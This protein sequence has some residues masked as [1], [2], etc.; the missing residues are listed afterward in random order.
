MRPSFPPERLFVRVA[1]NTATPRTYNAQRHARLTAQMPDH[2]LPPI[3]YLP[4]SGGYTGSRIVPEVFHFCF[5]HRKPDR[6]DQYSF[7]PPTVRGFS[8]VAT[9]ST[10]T[11][12]LFVRPGTWHETRECYPDI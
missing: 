7:R 8:S 12:M 9:A 5:L 3:V 2:P 6:F 10:T 11:E 4:S 1:K